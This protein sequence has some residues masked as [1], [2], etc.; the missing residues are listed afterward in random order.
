MTGFQIKK[1]ER[2]VLKYWF[3]HHQWT[4]PCAAAWLVDEPMH[5]LILDIRILDSF[6]HF[7]KHFPAFNVEWF[8]EQF[9]F[10]RGS[11]GDFDLFYP[12]FYV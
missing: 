3:Y 6:D 8:L 7:Q 11:L 10:E 5:N 1:V 2:F 4:M 9:L 12:E